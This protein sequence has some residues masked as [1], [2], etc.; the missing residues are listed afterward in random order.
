MPVFKAM[1]QSVV[2]GAVCVSNGDIVHSAAG[3]RHYIGR[4]P[5]TDI[6]ADIH[7]TPVRWRSTLTIGFAFFK[8]I[9]T[10]GIYGNMS[11]KH[12]LVIP[13]K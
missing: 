3:L 5:K 13:P 11:R 2:F 4:S 6:A 7:A 10:R 9:L 1:R 8:S 12:G